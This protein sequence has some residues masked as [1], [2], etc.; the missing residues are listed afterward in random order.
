M[1]R[2]VLRYSEAFKRQVI[3]DFEQGKFTSIAEIRKAYNIRGGG[4][5]QS[6]I[7]KYG[8]EE[9]L[10][11]KVKVETLSERDEL[12][13]AKKRIRQLEAALADVHIDS[14][15][16]HSFL[17]IACKRLGEDLTEFKK[18]HVTSLSKLRN[19]QRGLK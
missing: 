19:K 11:K 9:L 16:E 7:R 13:E 2:S 14:S 15:L 8:H 4:T 10:V 6:W 5:V 18:K 1:G 12:Q 17:Q 3:F